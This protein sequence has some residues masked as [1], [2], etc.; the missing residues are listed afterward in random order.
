MMKAAKKSIQEVL[1]VFC[2]LIAI[3]ILF[4]WYTTENKHRIEERNKNY[5]SDSARL[6]AVHIDEELNNALNRINT[7]T[8]FLGES[9]TEPAGTVQMLGTIEEHSQ[10]DACLF[11]D[12]DGTNYA[13]DGRTSVAD[14][15][16]Y[17]VN[18][19]KGED[20]I[21]VVYDSVFFDETMISFYAPVRFEGEII[22]VLRGTYLA[23]EYLKDMLSTTYF[24]EPAEVY[25]CM[26]NGEVIASSGDQ[27]Y[28]GDLLDILTES[29]VID[30]GTAQDAREVFTSGEEGAFVCDSNSTT[31]NICVM[32]LPGNNYVLVQTFPKNVTQSMIKAELQ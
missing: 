3:I 2:M 19:I 4:Q 31:D 15:H 7:Y 16:D 24:G 25:L 17:Y 10:F 1:Y 11:T 20:G 6:M 22:G 9:L 18:G 13:S 32:Y 21:T 30:A 26:P 23:E 8:F 28:T 29:G 5:A 12:K 14:T 27:C